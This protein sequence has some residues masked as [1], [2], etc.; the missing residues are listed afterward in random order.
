MKKL[1]LILTVFP[2]LCLGGTA[3]ALTA[4][5][6]PGSNLSKD[7]AATTV[8]DVAV[9]AG[10][11]AVFVAATNKKTSVTTI[12]F[13]VEGASTATVG[14]QIDLNSTLSGEPNPDPS[15]YISYV[16]VTASGLLSVTATDVQGS[17]STTNWGVYIVTGE[18]LAAVGQGAKYYASDDVT[19]GSATDTLTNS[20]SLDG[21][22]SSVWIVEALGGTKIDVAPNNPNN[23]IGYTVDDTPTYPDWDA[24]PSGN[25]F[26]GRRLIGDAILS[27]ERSSV[28]N[29]YDV[30]L[31]PGKTGSITGSVVGLAIA[32][33]SG[34]GGGTTWLG[35]DVDEN[36]LVDTGAWMGMLY[37]ES[38]PWIYSYDLMNWLYMPM[39]QDT[40]MGVWVYATN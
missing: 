10:D 7:A 8:A 12:A 25:T 38:D 2:L 23:L 20:Y 4:T 18:G 32:E 5:Y 9:S 11:M 27:G 26:P 34:G 6:Y 40:A 31:Q 29:S 13:S 39:E 28:G 14:A 35:F 3:N 16:P 21:T 24:A 15:C 1:H 19:I 30:V 33:T 22:Y 37:V 17:G 36:G